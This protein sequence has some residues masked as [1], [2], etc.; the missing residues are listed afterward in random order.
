[1][2]K[3]GFGLKQKHELCIQHCACV[4]CS[5]RYRPTNRSHG[6][7]GV[8]VNFQW[9]RSHLP[10]TGPQQEIWMGKVKSLCICPRLLHTLFTPHVGPYSPLGWGHWW[11]MCCVMGVCVCVYV[12]LYVCV[13]MLFFLPVCAHLW[14]CLMF[15]F[16]LFCLFVC[17]FWKL[18]TNSFYLLRV[19]TT[20]CS[21]LQIQK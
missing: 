21:F 4:P 17:L 8:V 19:L 20:T 1:M 16:F 10:S 12:S 3:S 2:F 14:M 7:D 6:S 18:T 9:Q 15:L 5:L 13:C 11:Q